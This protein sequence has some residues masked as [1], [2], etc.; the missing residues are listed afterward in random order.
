MGRPFLQMREG[1]L[2]R[3][4]GHYHRAL[5]PRSRQAPRS[6]PRADEVPSTRLV[7][8]ITAHARIRPIKERAG[9]LGPS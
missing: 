4:C 5:L 8:T 3:Q 7:M 6:A 1:Q 2:R 9:R